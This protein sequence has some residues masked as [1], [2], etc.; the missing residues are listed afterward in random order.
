[1]GDNS[2][3]IEFEEFITDIKEDRNCSS[4]IYDAIANLKIINKIYK[5]SGY[6]YNS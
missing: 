6:D 2:W 3:V 1:M 5:N 4:G